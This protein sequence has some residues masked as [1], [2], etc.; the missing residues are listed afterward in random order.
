MKKP[1]VVC[2]KEVDKKE[3]VAVTIF[4]CSEECKKER[5]KSM[6]KRLSVLNI[7]Y[8]TNLG[9]SKKDASEKVSSIQKERSPRCVEYW[10]KKGYTEEESHKKVSE[11]QKD[12]SNKRLEKTTKEDRKKSSMLCVEYWIAKGHS[13][14]KAKQIISERQK[15]NGV[16][17]NAFIWRHGKSEG[18]ARWKKFSETRKKDYTLEGYIKRHGEKKGRKLWSRKFK[19]R[20]DS[21]KAKDFILSVIENIPSDLRVYWSGSDSGEYGVLGD[22]SYYFYDLVIPDLGFVI[23]YH[24]DYWHCNPNTYD[25][26]YIHPHLGISA[27]EIWKK[28]EQ[29]KRTIQEKRKYDIIVVWESDDTEKTTQLIKEK[30]DGILKDKDKR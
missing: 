20:H 2:G 28:D 25:K 16:T 18:Y 14:D 17:L 7:E 9:L 29:K 4:L 5:K 3:S 24:G 26:D 12:N 23:E 22:D 15:K 19:N 21:K 30:I 6:P 10:I 13:I 8:W 1:C 11:V 27:E